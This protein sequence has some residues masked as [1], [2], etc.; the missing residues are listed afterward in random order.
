M[1][2]PINKNIDVMDKNF[3]NRKKPYQIICLILAVVLGVGCMFILQPYM[4]STTVTYVTMIFSVP[5]GYLGIY[6]KNGMDFFE[7]RRKKRDVNVTG[8]VVHKTDMSFVEK[9]AVIQNSNKN[10]LKVKKKYMKAVKKH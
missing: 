5:L 6:E 2:L 7:Y 10:S 8:K 9:N 4:S 3:L 1:N